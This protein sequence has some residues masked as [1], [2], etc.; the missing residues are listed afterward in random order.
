[1]PRTTRHSRRRPAPNGNHGFTNRQVWNAY[2][3]ARIDQEADLHAQT[4][5]QTIQAL[6]GNID[7]GNRLVEQKR[8]QYEQGKAIMARTEL[9]VTAAVTPGSDDERRERKRLNGNAAVVRVHVD[10][11]KV[12]LVTLVPKC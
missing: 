12:R 2:I 3:A 4:V 8:S 9:I 6:F 7:D 1:M 11:D 10:D 5:A